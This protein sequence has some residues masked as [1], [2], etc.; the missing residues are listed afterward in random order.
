M[1]QIS[2]H[3]HHLYQPGDVGAHG[4]RVTPGLA[5]GA[6]Q[7]GV[8]WLVGDPQPLVLGELVVDVA[9]AGLKFQWVDPGRY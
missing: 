8:G 7:D 1:F 4:G 6:V 9:E 3:I 2:I 5:H